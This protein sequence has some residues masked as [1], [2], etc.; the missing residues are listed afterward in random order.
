M[1]SQ[2]NLVQ[3]TSDPVPPPLPELTEPFDDMHDDS[4]E[5]SSP[6]PGHACDDIV[7]RFD[8]ADGEATKFR[9]RYRSFAFSAAFLGMVAV[10]MAI[11]ELHQEVRWTLFNIFEFSVAVAAVVCWV[12]MSQRKYRWLA[13]RHRAERYR[14]SKFRLL[15]TATDW[16]ISGPKAAEEWIPPS[17]LNDELVKIAALRTRKSLEE[18]ING[19][20]LHGPF[21]VSGKRLQRRTVRQIV[22]YYL[23]RRLN[24]QMA[25]LANRAQISALLDLLLRLLACLFSISV[26]AAGAH[27]FVVVV[28]HA[29]GWESARAQHRLIATIE[30][31][32]LILAVTLPVMA[33]W[34]RT[35][36]ASFEFSRNK[37]RFSAAQ[38]AL[39][40]LQ[41]RLV[42]AGFTS[43]PVASP[44][45]STPGAPVV[46]IDRSVPV[47]PGVLNSDED[48]VDAEKVLQELHWCEHILATEHIEWLRLMMETELF[49]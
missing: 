46:E 38:G 3:A 37:S 19:A 41:Y 28:V 24:P 30:I 44:S 6:L 17:W 23:T 16:A 7:A 36:R 12:L 2:P 48:W 25:Y 9:R 21:E 34:V 40:R 32:A 47:Q 43:L 33:A 11:F 20:A 18:V 35:M 45:R 5:P 15:L 31:S 8:V 39:F 10:I 4:K 49:G 14:Q 29:R 13:H 1:A 42:H 22:E 27:A 26:I